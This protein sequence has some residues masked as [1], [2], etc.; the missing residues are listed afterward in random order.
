MTLQF[1]SSFI[2][3]V[4]G[5]IAVGIA[6]AQDSTLGDVA[7]PTSSTVGLDSNSTFDSGFAD[8][9]PTAGSTDGVVMTT[10][11]F[12]STSTVTTTATTAAVTSALPTTPPF[13]NETYLISLAIIWNGEDVST[14]AKRQFAS[15][16]FPSFAAACPTSSRLNRTSINLVVVQLETLLNLDDVQILQNALSVSNYLFTGLKSSPLTPLLETVLSNTT[17]PGYYLMNY[18]TVAPMS[19]TLLQDALVK[20]IDQR[21]QESS[22]PADQRN[23]RAALFIDDSIDITQMTQLFRYFRYGLMFFRY[24]DGTVDESLISVRQSGIINI[25][26]LLPAVSG[27]KLK[28]AAFKLNMFSYNYRWF[29]HRARWVNANFDNRM[30]TYSTNVTSMEF[31]RV[32]DTLRYDL[33]T[34]SEVLVFDLESIWQPYLQQYLCDEKTPVNKT[35][36][37]FSGSFKLNPNGSVARLNWRLQIYRGLEAK[38]H[39]IGEW[40]SDGGF[41]MLPYPDPAR[42][43]ELSLSELKLN[44]FNIVTLIIPPY[45]MYK[46]GVSPEAPLRQR[47]TGMYIELCKE[48]LADLGIT[49]YDFFLQP[50]EAF[51]VFNKTWNGIIRTMMDGRAHL[52]CAPVTIETSRKEVV[53]F[54]KPLHSSQ[55]SILYKQPPGDPVAEMF[56]F[57]Q[58]LDTEIWLTILGV[59][60]Y[61]AIV[62]AVMHKIIPNQ[63][64]KLDLYDSLFFSFAEVVQGTSGAV[65]NQISGRIVVAFF[66]FFTLFLLLTYIANYAA[67][68]LLDGVQQQVDS[69][70][71]LLQ[72]SAFEFGVIRNTVTVTLLQTSTFVYM[73]QIYSLLADTFPNGLVHNETYALQIMQNDSFRYALIGD[74]LQNKY[75]AETQCNLVNTGQFYELKSALVLPPGNEYGKYFDEQIVRMSNRIIE[76]QQKFFHV[77]VESRKDCTDRTFLG[78]VKNYTPKN[79]WPVKSGALTLTNTLG[80]AMINLFGCIF[81]LILSAIERS[82]SRLLQRRSEVRR[83]TQ[84]AEAY[85]M[86]QRPTMLE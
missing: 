52:A 23:Y 29:V 16:I 34:T 58:P 76:L 19:L 77:P 40:T 55:Q 60:V 57:L 72:N 79:P 81:A 67:F 38:K 39:Q 25:I 13:N 46:S 62:L 6:T 85:A 78:Y 36:R 70:Q 43:P 37:G 33:R 83:K 24:T 68:R 3:L 84:V 49:D 2:L 12:T 53:S 15:Y 26:V 63:G 17:V 73:Q 86:A 31:G 1:T 51:G 32:H 27:D 82:F 74:D 47:L 28:L 54:T 50:D 71:S 75:L 59:L 66:W 8:T 14:E 11:K 4:I 65:P 45:V 44:P 35:L 69:L 20:V 5:C 42:T 56:Q 10:T 9:A 41:N 22:N 48:I 30:V 7:D 80:I 64:I 18:H 61:V 21:I